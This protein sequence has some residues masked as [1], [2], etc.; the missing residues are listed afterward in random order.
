[1]TIRKKLLVTGCGRS[2]TKYMSVLLRRLGVDVRNESMGRDGVASWCMAVDSRDSAWGL[3]SAGF[4]FDHVFHQVRHPL[5]VIS[6]A[7]SFRDVSWQFICAHAPISIVEPLTLRCAKYWYYWN[8]AAER[9]ADWRYRIEELPIIFEDYCERLGLEPNWGI[10]DGLST[11]VNTRNRGRAFHIYQ[12]ICV[13]LGL[14]ESAFLR[15]ALST[16]TDTRQS[17][18]V[19][20]DGLRALDP[21]LCEHI[22]ERALAYGYPADITPHA[23]HGYHKTCR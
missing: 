17:S 20:W 1:M 8:L 3:A 9:V 5:A 18:V 19:S 21:V 23:N 10:L 11:E 12:E 6:S 2:G 15:E 14:K 13:R 4:S 7:H 22:Q 16:D